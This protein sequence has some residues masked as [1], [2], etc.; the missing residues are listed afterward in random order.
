MAGFGQIATVRFADV[1]PGSQILVSDYANNYEP[2]EAFVL[3]RKLEYGPQRIPMLMVKADH[4]P[5]PILLMADGKTVVKILVGSDILIP[6]ELSVNVQRV[7]AIPR[8]VQALQFM[9]GVDSATEI[10]QFG[11]SGAAAIR[12]VEATDQSP[13]YMGIQSLEGETRIMLG[14]WAIKFTDTNRVD[15]EAGAAIADKYEG[16]RPQGV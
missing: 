5:D 12:W 10:I 7:R 3:D 8:E 16:F 6:Q 14:D 15:A 13:E 9:G 2:F 1:R 11:A 4:T